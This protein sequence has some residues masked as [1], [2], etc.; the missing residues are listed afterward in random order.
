M[1]LAQKEAFAGVLGGLLQVAVDER[2]GVDI[3]APLKARIAELEEALAH[4]EARA[5]RAHLAREEERVRGD[6]FHDQ[7]HELREYVQRQ[8]RSL[9]WRGVKKLHDLK[10]K[11]GPASEQHQQS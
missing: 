7:L 9:I 1:A 2:S 10:T 8:E 3:S 6:G 11:L 4:V 5:E